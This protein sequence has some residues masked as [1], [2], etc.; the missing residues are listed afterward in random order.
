MSDEPVDALIARYLK[1]EDD[2]S[3]V[4]KKIEAAGRDVA[5]I[6]V[7]LVGSTEL[8]IERLLN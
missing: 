3:L 5:V 1:T 8:A 7:D 2:L 6:F 4:G